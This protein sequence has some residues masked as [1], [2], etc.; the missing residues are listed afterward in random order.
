MDRGVPGDIFRIGG[1]L[2]VYT[3]LF[4]WQRLRWWEGGRRLLMSD[5]TIGEQEARRIY[6]RIKA[7]ERVRRKTGEND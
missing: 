5:L 2:A 4:G 1:R 6:L 7:R 3:G